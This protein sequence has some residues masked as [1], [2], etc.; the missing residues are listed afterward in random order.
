MGKKINT[1]FLAAFIELENACNGLLGCKKSGVTEYINRLNSSDSIPGKSEV[2]PKLL[3]YRK[4]RNRL[5]HEEGALTDV[6]EIKNS[7]LR[8]LKS[9]KNSVE[10]GRDPISKSQ[11][12][13]AGLARRLTAVIAIIA[14][15]L[16]VAVGIALLVSN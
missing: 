9:F 1:E 12:R 14:A 2:L 4:L 3:S 8:W 5:A 15:V 11:R 10:K 16:T 6:S 13:C 7:D